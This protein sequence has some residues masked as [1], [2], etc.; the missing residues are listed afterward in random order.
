[1]HYVYLLNLDKHRYYV[2]ETTRLYKRLNEHGNPDT[3]SSNHCLNYEPKW[4][5][6]VYDVR[7]NMIYRQY[8]KILNN[9]TYDNENNFDRLD[10]ILC[11]LSKERCEMFALHT[12]RSLHQ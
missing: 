11:H 9:I 12:W 7:K 8:S 3:Y 6:G 10:D 1:M 2:G 4:L 5:F